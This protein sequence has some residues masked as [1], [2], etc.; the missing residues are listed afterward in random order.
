MPGQVAELVF[1]GCSDG[2]SEQR[3]VIIAGQPGRMH[4]QADGA[5]TAQIRTGAGSWL[6]RG[7]SGRALCPDLWPGEGFCEHRQDTLCSGFP[8]P[9]SIARL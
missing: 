8:W 5:L 6:V 3:T 1:T 9:G 4:S 2:C 7:T